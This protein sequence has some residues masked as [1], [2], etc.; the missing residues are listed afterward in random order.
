MG[1]MFEEDPRISQKPERPALIE[2]ARRMGVKLNAAEPGATPNEQ[3][4]IQREIKRRTAYS[5]FILDRYQASGRYRPQIINIDELHVQLPCSEE[6]FQFGS[7]VKT[8]SLKDSPR[9]P[10]SNEGSRTIASTQFLSIYIRLVEIW[11]RFSRWSCR[12]GR[13]E[14]AY[15]PWDERSEFYKLRQQLVSF[16]DSLPPKLTFSP[17]KISGHIASGSITLYTAIHTL[18]SLCNIVLHREYIPFLPLRSDGPSGP[19][20]EPTFP[21]DKYDI[22]EG[23]WDESAELIFKSARDIMD[24]VR[25]TSDRQV[26]VESPQVGFA[27]WTAAFVGIYSNHFPY[28][29]KNSYMSN[30]PT[31]PDRNLTYSNSLNDATAL[32]VRTLKLMLPRSKMACGW[33]VW[34]QRMRRYFENIKKDYS[35]SIAALGLPSSE[36]QRRVALAELSL[37]EGGHGGGLEEYK[38]LEKELNDFGP[39][40]QQ[41]R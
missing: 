25:V 34:L 41:D 27:V 18:Y 19:L 9:S 28:M 8:G 30:P 40:L 3:T 16:H 26:M 10:D 5:C 31:T 6:D 33:S 39:S 2:E 24:I 14:E 38:L 11:G 36:H 12:G 35:R 22:P 1:L 23:F 4:L 7:N 20:D 21:P 32:A 13:R 37:R 29:D 17:T 15:P